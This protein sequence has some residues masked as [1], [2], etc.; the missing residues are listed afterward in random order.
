MRARGRSA[1]RPW[2]P[3]SRG[4]GRLRPR[5]P[6][7]GTAP[8]PNPAASSSFPC[9]SLSFPSARRVRRAPSKEGGCEDSGRALGS[10][11]GTGYRARYPGAALIFH[12]G[13]D[14]SDGSTEVLFQKTARRPPEPLE[15][16][17]ACWQRGCHKSEGPGSAAQSAATSLWIWC[18]CKTRV[19]NN[20]CQRP[21]RWGRAVLHM[22]WM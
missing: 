1:G 7:Q 15:P 14:P 13:P 16:R 9:L 10:Q 22:V 20:W 17:S 4:G 6:D 21:C 18:V 8:T 3:G 19:R 2:A 5:K 11:S 12:L